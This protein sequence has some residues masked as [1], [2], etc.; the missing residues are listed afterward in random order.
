MF[1]KVRN[2]VDD[3]TCTEHRDGCMSRSNMICKGAN[4]NEGKKGTD[5]DEG[6][7]GQTPING[8]R[9]EGQGA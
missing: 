3:G 1:H 2:I 8:E 9:E 4:E 7:R 6:Q 5:R